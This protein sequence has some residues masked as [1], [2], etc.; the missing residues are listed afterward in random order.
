MYNQF[1]SSTQLNEILVRLEAAI[2]QLQTD[3]QI[4]SIGVFGSYV[5]NKQT[6]DS[7]L[8]ILVSFHEVPSL[9]T[10]IEL[11]NR[12]TDLLGVKVDLVM[13]EALKPKIGERIMSEVVRV[14]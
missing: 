6:A 8:D 10:F 3:Y 9:F 1:M 4:E 5:K 13:E 11:E 2:P 12:L 14:P 7:D